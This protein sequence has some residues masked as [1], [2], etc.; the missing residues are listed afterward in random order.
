MQK[1]PLNLGFANM[2]GEDLEPLVDEDHAALAPL[3][4]RAVRPPVRQMPGAHILFVYVHLE[5]DG[6]M[7]GFK[8]SGLR[9]IVQLTKAQVV[10]L[11]NENTDANIIAAGKL[12][13]PKTANLIFTNNRNGPGFARFFR[14]LF[15]EMAKGQDML[16]AWAA[17][18]PQGGRQADWLPGTIVL[19][20]AGKLAFPV[21]AR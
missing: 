5:A 2:S 8:N 9:Q 1:I 11:A 18:V 4:A 19:A 14:L 10:V 3:F 12:P 21:A 6:T 16:S 20:E 7:R 13:G 15:E 17:L